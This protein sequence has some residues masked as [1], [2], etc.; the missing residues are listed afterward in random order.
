MTKRGDGM[1]MVCVVR[2]KT[3]SRAGSVLAGI[4]CGSEP[5]REEA[6]TVNIDVV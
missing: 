5:A 6:G 2:L 4:T 1:V 3:S